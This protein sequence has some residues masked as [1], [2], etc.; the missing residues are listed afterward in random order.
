M[1]LKPLL[2]NHVLWTAM[3]AW[4]LAQV[5]KIPFDYLRNREWDWAQFFAAGGMPSSHSALITSATLGAGLHQG[6]DSPI[7]ALGVA[8]SMI[9][10]YD[11][12]GVRRQAGIQAQKI[13]AMVAELLKGNPISEEQLREV[14]GHTPIEVASGVLLGLAVAFISWLIMK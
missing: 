9:V 12:A 5:L 1:N 4:I 2:E 3:V 11:A 14:I 7:F 13:N 10:I 6:F 8:I